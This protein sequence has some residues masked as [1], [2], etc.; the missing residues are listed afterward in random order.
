MVLTSVDFSAQAAEQLLWV[1]T[2][3]ALAIRGSPLKGQSAA[4]SRLLLIR[5]VEVRWSYQE[6]RCC[7]SLCG[8]DVA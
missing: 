8:V 6:L 3:R 5:S 2:S 4:Q 1:A 7:P